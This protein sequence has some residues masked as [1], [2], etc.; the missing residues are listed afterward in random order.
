VAAYTLIRRMKTL[1]PERPV[2]WLSLGIGGYE[3]NPV[4]YTQKTP[5][6]PMATRADRAY[7]DA[8]AAWLA[9]A[10]T[11]W[12]STWMFI[13]ATDKAASMAQ[14]RGVQI[15]V[16]D[17]VP[18]SKKLKGGISYSFGKAGKIYQAKTQ[19]VAPK[20]DDS[21]DEKLADLAVEELLK[22]KKDD[23]NP[24]T[25]QLQQEMERMRIGFHFYGKYVYDCA[26][27]FASLPRLN[28]RP[29]VLAVKPGL[30][31]WSRAAD[32]AAQGHNLLNAYDFLLDVNQVPDADLAR[33]RLIA[34]DGLD[35]APLADRTITSL[36]GWLMDLPGLLYVHGALSTDAANEASTTVDHDGVLKERWPWAGQVE[37]APSKTAAGYKVSGPNAKVLAQGAQGP[38]LVLWRAPGHKGA[39]LFDAGI[40]DAAEL[41]DIINNLAREQKVGVEL[42]G[43][44]L[45]TVWQETGM[46][47]AASSGG[48]VANVVPGVD[49]LTGL[50]NPAVGPGRSGALVSASLTGKYA[51]SLNGVA[52]L[53]E[54]PLEEVT[55]VEGGLRVRC[56]GLLQAGGQS[57]AVTVAVEG[58]E[59]LPAIEPAKIN[60][61]MLFGKEDGFCTRPIADNPASTVTYI[62]SSRPV[63][64]RTKMNE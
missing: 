45:Q 33:Y 9:G 35:N 10:D 16:E 28:P 44:P 32:F 22:E 13:G 30:S 7:A 46:L 48:S 51:A 60:E 6:A 37:L 20:I 59:S 27:V 8:V 12:F 1:W 19:G 15:V 50:P 41:R 40:K 5:D 2:L 25:K 21:R 61:W 43:P 36:S 26:R 42:T 39:V 52:V 54:K 3:M 38:V 31:V 23:D 17:I 55:P 29:E 47:A 34:L 58:G 56:A 62:R 63:V 53:G 4:R 49:L 14:L 24:I 11:G 64:V 18:D 57:G